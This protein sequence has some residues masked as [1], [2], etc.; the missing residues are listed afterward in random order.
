MKLVRLADHMYITSGRES[1]SQN[2]CAGKY[3]RLTD[4]RK[5]LIIEMFDMR[6]TGHTQ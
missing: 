3:T 5:Q 6:W 4:V 2:D 1:H